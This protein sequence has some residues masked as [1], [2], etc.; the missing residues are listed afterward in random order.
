MTNLAEI[1]WQVS[2]DLSFSVKIDNIEGKFFQ[3]IIKPHI[4]T[5]I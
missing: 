1:L 5:R 2:V 4:G 3:F